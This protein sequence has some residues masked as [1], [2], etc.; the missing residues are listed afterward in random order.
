VTEQPAPCPGEA[1]LAAFVDKS[2]RGH[3]RDAIERHLHACE[4]C[5]ET[6]ACVVAIDD[7][8]PGPHASAVG[9]T[10]VERPR[11][12]RKDLA[13]PTRGDTVGRFVLLDLLG[14]GGMG[15]VYAA[16]DPQ[17]DRKVAIKLLRAADVAAGANDDATARLLREAQAMARSTTSAPMAMRSIS[18]WSSPTPARCA[19]GSRRDGRSTR[20]STSSSRPAAAS[21]PRTPPA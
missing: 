19:R 15:L 10:R 17:L 3:D 14:V 12:P 8:D 11:G 4:G 9:S 2:L 5:R 6:V 21:P 20:S 1:A 16:Y 18:R 7:G 13:D